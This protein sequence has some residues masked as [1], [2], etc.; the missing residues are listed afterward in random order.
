MRLAADI[1]GIIMRASRSICPYINTRVYSVKSS[2]YLQTNYFSSGSKAAPV[3]EIHHGTH[4]PPTTEALVEISL[5]P[6]IGEGS[7]KTPKYW[8][9]NVKLQHLIHTDII[10]S[11]RFVIENIKVQYNHDLLELL[12]LNFTNKHTLEVS[13][14][15]IELLIREQKLVI[16][17]EMW[18]TYL[19]LTCETFS[20]AGAKLIFHNVLDCHNLYDQ[21]YSVYNRTQTNLPFLVTPG[22]LEQLSLIFQRNQMLDHIIILRDY[23]KRFYSIFATRRYFKTISIALVESYASSGDIKNALGAFKYLCIMCRNHQNF[24]PRA[25]HLHKVHSAFADA[26]KWRLHNL[27]SNSVKFPVW[28]PEYK[29]DLDLLQESE[30]GLD[31]LYRP[32]DTKNNTG[33]SL[34][35]IDGSIQLNDLPQFSRLVS[36]MVNS[37]MKSDSHQKIANLVK[38]I[39]A[40]HFVLASF[41]VSSLASNNYLVEALAVMKKAQVKH[42]DVMLPVMYKDDVFMG[43]IRGCKKRLATMDSNQLYDFDQLVEFNKLINGFTE[44]YLLVKLKQTTP[45]ID[46][47]ILSLYISL[48]LESPK[49]SAIDVENNLMKFKRLTREKI[50]LPMDEYKR[51]DEV[52]GVST[53]QFKDVI[54]P[55]H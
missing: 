35:V 13:V 26:N 53:N 41:I 14:S 19:S 37:H 23:L 31:N 16:S 55:K 28:E 3:Q 24:V 8:E 1:N 48:M 29:S 52:F 27:A 38:L 54:L 46:S 45:K 49:F 47:K 40:N 30:I 10:A 44:F 17:N 43:I 7:N 42:I 34:P 5:K 36:Q 11:V 51:L 39:K 12:L 32:I 2:R 21:D 50:Y 22:N 15:L 9:E 4:N 25:E 18:S 6:P 33:R 20:V